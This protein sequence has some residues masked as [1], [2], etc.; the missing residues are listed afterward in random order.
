[1]AAKEKWVA[2]D[3]PGARDILLDAFQQNPQSQ[4]I[5]LAG[6]GGKDGWVELKG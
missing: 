4:Q 5:W 2:G 3:V 1:M 6:E